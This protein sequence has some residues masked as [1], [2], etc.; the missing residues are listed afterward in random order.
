MRSL[1]FMLYSLL[2]TLCPVFAT[3]LPGF[4]L[5]H[6]G[7]VDPPLDR[8]GFSMGPPSV[9]VFPKAVMQ[10]ELV[11]SLLASIDKARV[12]TFLETL[13]SFPERYYL[14]NNGVKAAE[15]IRDQV[16]SYRSMLSPDVTLTVT[17]FEHS[18]KKQPSVIARLEK[19]A[20]TNYQDI[21]IVG[22]HFDTLGKGSG[23]PE[24]NNN[25]G[26]DDCS[27]ASSALAEALLVLVKNKF[28]PGRPI[29]FHWYAAEEV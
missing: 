22:T 29:E 1:F 28:V 18:W 2:A 15:W 10:K 16:L 21:V 20:P 5:S 3:P 25:P 24:P 17:L 8:S 12:K 4:G 11:D 6:Q 13:S 26:A 9:S 27:S 14:S 23:K 7:I 19:K